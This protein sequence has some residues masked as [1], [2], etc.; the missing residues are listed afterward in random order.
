MMRKNASISTKARRRACGYPRAV[1]VCSYLRLKGYDIGDSR[2]QLISEGMAVS[3]SCVIFNEKCDTEEKRKK[4]AENMNKEIE[5]QDQRQREEYVEACKEYRI[6][7]RQWE[8][9]VVRN[10]WFARKNYKLFRPGTTARMVNAALEKGEADNQLEVDRVFPLYYLGA[11]ERVVATSIHEKKM[12]PT[13]SSKDISLQNE[14][15]EIPD[16]EALDMPDNESLEMPDVSETMRVPFQIFGAETYT[17][18]QRKL[19]KTLVEEACDHRLGKYMK[20][21]LLEGSEYDNGRGSAAD[22]EAALNACDDETSP[23]E[24]TTLREIFNEVSKGDAIT[25]NEMIAAEAQRF[26]WKVHRSSS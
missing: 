23:A 25:I 1:Q 24:L 15:L 13:P 7:R 19:N 26:S 11:P 12:L 18:E 9:G 14:A 20:E 4:V 8:I 16:D 22:V 5:S 21:I 2:Y 17:G 3:P 10:E 6:N